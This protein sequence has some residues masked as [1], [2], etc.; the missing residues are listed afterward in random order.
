[1]KSSF[2]FGLLFLV[3]F[4]LSTFYMVVVK[5][6]V[7]EISTE[8]K[9]RDNIKSL[10][11]QNITE[12]SDDE[13]I[14]SSNHDIT[15][16]TQ[17]STQE[18]RFQRIK[19]NIER[20]GGPVAIA[21]NI[22]QHSGGYDHPMIKDL[23]DF[24]KLK[25]RT[26]DV[27]IIIYEARGTSEEYPVN[28]MRNLAISQS[29]TN[30]I[31]YIDVDFILSSNAYGWL[32]QHQNLLDNA[33]K[34]YQA[35]ILPAFEYGKSVPDIFTKE[36]L[37][38]SNVEE[39]HKNLGLHR[40]TNYS[41]W[42]KTDEPYS[43]QY[44]DNGRFEPYFVVRRDVP[45]YDERFLGRGCNKIA[46]VWELAER[47]Y[48]FQVVPHHFIYHLKHNYT[49]SGNQ[50]KILQENCERLFKRFKRETKREIRRNRKN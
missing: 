16:V 21:V 14:P 12:L 8:S 9:S 11:T 20:W 40:N 42:W 5:N 7:K 45:F 32:V 28:F 23:R 10:F 50:R 44:P 39:F 18:F 26:R 33:F 49:K 30:F 36:Q 37:N 27:S 3:I 48:E 31:F 25:K 35:L 1:M 41:K 22:P 13:S 4:S 15:L 24:V 43:I 38:N 2:L 29:W 17:T 19:W 6:S 34:K 46:Q 47:G